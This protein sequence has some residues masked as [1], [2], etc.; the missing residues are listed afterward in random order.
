MKQNIIIGI[1]VAIIVV[2]LYIIFHPSP[3]TQRKT[4]SV[5]QIASQ[6]PLEQP[7]TVI[8][9][10]A[11]TLSNTSPLVPEF[12]I[13]DRHNSN[14]YNQQA[15]S[16]SDKYF[17]NSEPQNFN[18][19]YRAEP[20]QNYAQKPKEPNILSNR[21]RDA[22]AS[23]LPHVP[24]V[25]RPKSFE[26]NLSMCEPYKETMTTEYMG[27]KMRYNIEIAGWINNKCVLNFDANMLDA[28][29]TFEDTYGFEP[30]T[31][32]VFGFAPK[33]R[34]EFTKKQLLYVGDNILQEKSKD[35]KMLKDPNQIEFPE[36]KDMSISDIKLLQIILNDRACKVV[37]ANDFIQIFQSLFEF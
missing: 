34:C 7:E 12:R 14:S 10:S 27:M 16:S 20:E 32:E 3:V 28:G 24:V 21:D 11:A 26:S 23:V 37:N 29:T 2:L 5:S 8:E 18:R 25:K 13:N 4:E 15:E 1:L 31:V 36:M 22:G 33:V 19:S 9:N 30:G 35:R 17:T 6:T